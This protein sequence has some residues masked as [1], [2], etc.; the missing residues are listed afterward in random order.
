MTVRIRKHTR[1]K[2][3]LLEIYTHL[4]NDSERIAD[5][6]LAN[7]AGTYFSDYEI[8]PDGQSFVVLQ[9][10]EGLADQNHVILVTRWFDVLKE[11]F[12]GS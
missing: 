2:V 10:G 6:F 1:A 5:K 12:P 7:I 8:A 4:G 9:G 3:D 11:T